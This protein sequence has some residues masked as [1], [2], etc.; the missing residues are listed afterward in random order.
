MSS[1]NNSADKGIG[2]EFVK[3]V[4]SNLSSTMLFKA[5][6]LETYILYP[7][8][9]FTSLLNRISRSSPL[10]SIF[11]HSTLL[12]MCVW[13]TTKL[14]MVQFLYAAKDPDSAKELQD[15]AKRHKQI[16]VYR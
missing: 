16:C 13:E 1:L 11:H 6:C 10:V 3:Q 7:F 4:R 14:A 2:L 9:L 8:H 5:N 12:K 15:L